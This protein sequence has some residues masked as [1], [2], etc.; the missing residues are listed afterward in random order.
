M[1]EASGFEA[2]TIHRLLEADP[3]A[4]GL[5]NAAKTTRSHVD[6]LV[7]DETSMVDDAPHASA[8]GGGSGRGRAAGLSATSINRSASVGPGQ[9]LASTSSRPARRRWYG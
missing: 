2:K 8:D 6:L 3:R 1:T 9:V 4:G 5:P 7:I